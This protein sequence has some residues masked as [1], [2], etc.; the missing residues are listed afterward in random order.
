MGPICRKAHLEQDYL[1]VWEVGSLSSG[2][3]KPMVEFFDKVSSIN[4]TEL[5]FDPHVSVCCSQRQQGVGQGKSACLGWL[6]DLE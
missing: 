2:G 5:L 6:C 1:D 3:K 4:I